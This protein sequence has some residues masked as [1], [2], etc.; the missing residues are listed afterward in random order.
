MALSK[1]EL[2]EQRK[3]RYHNDP[4]FRERV[5]SS[6][7]RYHAN[8]RATDPEYLKSRSEY[9]KANAAY[10]NK[11]TKQYNS[12]RPFHYAFKR[13]RLR[14]RQHSLP[15]DLDEDYLV[16]LWTGQCAIFGTPLCTPYSTDRQV[17]DK[18]TIDRIVPELGYIKGNVQWVSNQANTI[19]SFGTL[20]EH[21]AVVTYMKKHITA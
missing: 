19:K 20:E 2:A 15:F 12:E 3:A 4:V 10:F 21:E 13:L 11:K 17:P 14:A 7:K 16:E 6:A 5:L 18:A 8:K 9:N 1:Q